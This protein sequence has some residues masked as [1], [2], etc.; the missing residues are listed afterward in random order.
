MDADDSS[1]AHN[2]ENENAD[3]NMQETEPENTSLNGDHDA[4]E[5]NSEIER[6]I[7]H[8]TDDNDEINTKMDTENEAN[9]SNSENDNKSSETTARNDDEDEVSVWK[10]NKTFVIVKSIFIRTT[11]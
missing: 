11:F 3:N 9:I 2:I 1:F 8:K 7:E 4:I 5:E 10:E 6:P